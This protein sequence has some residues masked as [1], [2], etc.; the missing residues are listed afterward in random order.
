M[1]ETVDPRNEGDL[2]AADR[3]EERGLGYLAL[4][5]RGEVVP[6]SWMLALFERGDKA[7]LPLEVGRMYSL[8]GVTSFGAPARG[9][10][11]DRSA[12]NFP[13]DRSVRIE[14]CLL[15]PEPPS[16]PIAYEAFHEPSND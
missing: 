10:I 5:M 16:R 6:P 2:I 15:R 14:V 13:K 11:T 7:D 9:M 3:M 12:P 8:S 1:S 4:F